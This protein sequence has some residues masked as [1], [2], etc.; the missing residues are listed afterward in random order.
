[1]NIFKVTLNLTFT[2]NKW[3][4]NEY[5]NERM[6]ID[7]K[8]IKQETF[9]RTKAY[10]MDNDLED[11]I[12][13]TYDPKEMVEYLFFEMDIISEWNEDTFAIDTI[14][15]TEKT[16]QDLY[17]TLKRHSLDDGEYEACDE[18]GWLIYTRGPNGEGYQD[19]DENKVDCWEYGSLDYRY[20]PIVIKKLIAIEELP[21]KDP[22][23]TLY[24]ALNETKDLIIKLERKCSSLEAELE[25]SKRMNKVV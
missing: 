1:M 17:E 20:N 11:Y 22:I 7:Q 23:Q 8:K 21:K 4:H 2:P 6:N 24:T 16:K 14:V 19:Y 3:D 25:A 10:Y 15:K 9:S 5:E 13:K 12:K 18:N